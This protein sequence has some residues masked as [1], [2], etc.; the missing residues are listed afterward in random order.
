[1]L[2]L[3]FKPTYVV[4]IKVRTRAV[5]V[6][7]ALRYQFRLQFTKNN[8]VRLRL[9]NTEI[10]ILILSDSAALIGYEKYS[11]KIAKV[12]NKIIIKNRGKTYT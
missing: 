10:N 7:T 2:V 5:G 4:Y 1:M 11:F 6:G 12:R 3:T 9:R 8:S